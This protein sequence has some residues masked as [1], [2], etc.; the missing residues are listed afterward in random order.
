MA[1]ALRGS[2]LAGPSVVRA[3]VARRGALQVTNAITREKKEKIVE[4]IRTHL[5]GSFVTLG[6]NFK[7][8]TVQEVQVTRYLGAACQYSGA[9]SR[10]G[11]ATPRR[12]EPTSCQ[13]HPGPA[14]GSCPVSWR[15]VRFEVRERA[16]RQG[17]RGWDRS[18]LATPLARWLPFIYSPPR[19][20]RTGAAP[21]VTPSLLPSDPTASRARGP[22][23]ASWS[24]CERAEG[25]QDG[26][27]RRAPG[28]GP[29]PG[30]GNAVIPFCASRRSG[31][32][33]PRT[34][35]S[36]WPRTRS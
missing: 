19:C 14:L 32:A 3:S 21:T 20:G 8:L 22:R 30:V 13:P 26:V 2:P 23:R 18:P 10:L 9:L 6:V 31:G 7:G 16:V 15:R 11:Q 36:W 1:T 28:S 24:V 5:D 29:P 34:P 35:S 12:P 27:R 33:C 17:G 4:K 25:G